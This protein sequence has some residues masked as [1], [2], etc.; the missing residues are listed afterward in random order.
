MNS[1]QVPPLLYD[2][3]TPTQTLVNSTLSKVRRQH[4]KKRASKVAT[5]PLRANFLLETASPEDLPTLI[6]LLSRAG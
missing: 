4:T 5:G 6:D 3:A 2:S 1:P